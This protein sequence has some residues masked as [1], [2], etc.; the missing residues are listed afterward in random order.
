MSNHACVRLI[1]GDQLNPNH[2][3]FTT[4]DPS[5]MY[6]MMEVRSETDYVRHHAQKVLAIFAAMRR[7]ADTLRAGGHAVRYIRIG[8]PDNLHT[9]RDNIAMVMQECGAAT[10]EHMQSD[11]WRVDQH[12]GPTQYTTE[13]FLSERDDVALL[14]K[15]KKRWLMETFYRQMRLRYNVLMDADQQPVG[16]SWNYDE[17]NRRPWK[18]TP[19]E[20]VDMR[21][22]HDCSTLWKEITDAGVQTMGNAHA[23]DLRWPLDA[24]EA[25]AI[26][27]AFLDNAL[28]HFGTY[29]D[30][31]SLKARRLFHALI[32]FPLNVKMLHPLDVVRQAE[33]RYHR[34]DAPIAAVEGFIRQILGWREY[35]RGIYWSQ[36]PSYV[37]RNALNNHRALPSWFWTGETKMR[38]VGDAVDASLDSAYAHHIQRLMITGNIALL[39]GCAPHEVHQWYLGV[40]IDAFEWVEVPNTIGM[41]QHADHGLMATKPYVSSAAYIHRMSDACGSCAYNHKERLG[42]TA[43]PFNA[44]YWNFYM[45]HDDA[46]RNNVRVAMAYRHIDKMSADERE[47]ITERAAWLIDH[48]DEI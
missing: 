47:A 34:G 29:Q 40:Y 12:L 27:T 45:Q 8:D 25:Q 22:H 2:S 9:L 14:F 23:D 32:S 44:L 42:D 1:L 36:M 33:E 43:C 39:L 38:C 31:I 15:G 10:C 28:P 5:V 46:L 48:A 41:S 18:G 3:W 24:A 26:L 20:P 19:P 16:G 13:H 21:P 30:A 35:V 37:E 17:E 11:E 6:V 4:V 7:F